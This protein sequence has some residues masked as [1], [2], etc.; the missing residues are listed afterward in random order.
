MP[1]IVQRRCTSCC[2]PVE[3]IPLQAEHHSGRR[4]KVFAFP[5][6]WCSPSERNAVRIHNGMV[7]AF[8]PES[9]SPSTGFPSQFDVVWRSRVCAVFG[10]VLIQ[11]RNDA[12][13]N[14][15]AVPSG[16]EMPVDVDRDVHALVTGQLLKDTACG[17]TVLRSRT[18]TLIPPDAHGDACRSSGPPDEAQA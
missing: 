1:L 10:S 8:T 15:R 2:S 7:F 9:R 6:E 18:I 11:M 12:S 13:L 17:P 16:R 14:G 5:P 3:N 4:A